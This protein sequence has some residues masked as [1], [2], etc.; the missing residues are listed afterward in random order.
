RPPVAVSG[1]AAWGKPPSKRLQ[2]RSQAR[3]GRRG[4]A[5]T[6]SHSIYGEIVS[7]GPGA[8]GARLRRRPPGPDSTGSG[9]IEMIYAADVLAMA[10]ERREARHPAIRRRR[11]SCAG[12]ESGP[13][14]A[15]ARVERTG[16]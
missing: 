8:P 10:P 1:P 4:A 11:R 12:I 9:R 2:A 16:V 7:R 15:P 6:P 13:A 3:R 14:P 5:G